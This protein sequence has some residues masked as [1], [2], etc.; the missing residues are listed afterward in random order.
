MASLMA[1]HPNPDH[2]FSRDVNLQKIIDVGCGVRLGRRASVLTPRT[3][4]QGPLRH[5]RCVH[6]PDMQV[7]TLT[8]HPMSGATKPMN[9]LPMLS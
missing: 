6:M 3:D 9:A 8:S 7:Q 4:M 2:F 1:V 5:D